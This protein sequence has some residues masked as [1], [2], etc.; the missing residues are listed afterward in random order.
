MNTLSWFLYLTGIVPNILA[1]II[2]I[3]VITIIV[4]TVIYI[5][6]LF[7]ENGTVWG[8]ADS[9]KRKSF[10]RKAWWSVVSSFLVILV[11][12]FVPSQKTLYMIAA[13]EVGQTVVQTPEAQEILD[14]L[15]A[16]IKDVLTID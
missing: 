1:F 11:M 6:T 8:P 12:M 5:T 15:R 3:S 7:Y 16:K 2:T 14:L 4:G 9:E 10:R 13:S